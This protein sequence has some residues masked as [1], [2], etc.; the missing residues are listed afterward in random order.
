MESAMNLQIAN[1]FDK[2]PKGISTYEYSQE[3]IEKVASHV[4]E[5]Y[6][7]FPKLTAPQRDELYKTHRISMNMSDTYATIPT[8]EQCAEFA[9][10]LKRWII[11]SLN[12]NLGPHGS[13][14]KLKTDSCPEREWRL[15]AESIFQQQ[16]KEYHSLGVLFPYKT[17][18]TIHIS[19]DRKTLDVQLF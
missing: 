19:H 4:S 2:I 16:A 5:I 17:F 8:D 1:L 9:S 7:V 13:W 3:N 6:A 11:T 18:T 15:V 14:V 12:N 10:A